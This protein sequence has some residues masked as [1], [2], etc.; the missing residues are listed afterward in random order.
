M[1]L[2]LK[3]STKFLI[4]QKEQISA[5]NTLIEN[6]VE[7]SDIV[8]GGDFGVLTELKS[9][10]ELVSQF[11]T[12]M[13]DQITSQFIQPFQIFCNFKFREIQLSKDH[14]FKAVR[15][16]QNQLEQF[17]KTSVTTDGKIDPAKF[18]LVRFVFLL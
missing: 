15:E 11:Q 17:Q 1:R 6:M 13:C 8:D 7:L 12:S 4:A 5:T 9:S 2:I 16:Y 14:V 3:N 18:L 10:L